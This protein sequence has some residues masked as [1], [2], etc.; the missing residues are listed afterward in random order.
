MKLDH[1]MDSLESS[2]VTK[3]FYYLNLNDFLYF[4]KCLRFIIFKYRKKKEETANP[5]TSLKMVR[6]IQ[7]K[8]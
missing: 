8:D 6:T 3:V 5:L 2:E 1:L 4:N 7:G